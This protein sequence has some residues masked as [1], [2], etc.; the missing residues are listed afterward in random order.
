MYLEPASVLDMLA[1]IAADAAP[2]SVVV[3]DCIVPPAAIVDPA[4]RARYEALAERVAAIGEPWLGYFE[5]EDLAGKLRSA[6]FRRVE[7]FGSAALNSRYF[8]GRTDGLAVRPT[9]HLITAQL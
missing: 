5:P 8:A 4:L 6:G 9:V 1:N 2:G 3:F 7:D